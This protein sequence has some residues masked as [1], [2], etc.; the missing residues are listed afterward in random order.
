[1]TAYTKWDDLMSYG[2]C[3]FVV[4]VV[5]FVVVVFV[6]VVVVGEG[7]CCWGRLFL[8]KN[9]QDSLVFIF[10]GSHHSSTTVCCCWHNTYSVHMKFYRCVHLFLPL[11]LLHFLSSTFSSVND[12]NRPKSTGTSPAFHTSELWTRAI[13]EVVAVL[14]TLSGVGFVLLTAFLAIWLFTASAAA[15]AI[16]TGVR[17]F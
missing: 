1:M 7:F 15:A 17:K 16:C 3:V 14:G 4:V 5:V 12:P 2:K 13:T 9:K 6:V 8:S 10:F 11:S